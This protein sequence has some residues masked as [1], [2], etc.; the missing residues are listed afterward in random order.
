MRLNYKIALLSNIN[1]LH[2]D[3]LKNNFPV[4]DVFHNLLLSFELNLKKPD[5]LI[6]KKALGILNVLPEEAFYTDDRQELVEQSRRLGIHGFVFKGIEQLNK[7]LLD[8]GIK[9]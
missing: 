6:Y 3:Y 8:S 1:I 5:P 7:D 9:L 4:F 2:F